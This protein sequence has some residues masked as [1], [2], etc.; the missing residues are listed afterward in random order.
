ME[1]GRVK[2]TG[3]IYQRLGI[4]R[5]TNDQSFNLMCSRYRYVHLKIYETGIAVMTPSELTQQAFRL[6]ASIRIQS[7]KPPKHSDRRKRLHSVGLRA[8]YRYKRRMK[9]EQSLFEVSH[10]SF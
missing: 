6:Y 2:R 1:C 8:L 4:L 5:Y 7:Y 9:T 10:R 3:M